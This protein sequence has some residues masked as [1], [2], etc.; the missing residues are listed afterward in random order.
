MPN[1]RETQ[2][3]TLHFLLAALMFGTLWGALEASVGGLLHAAL[4][5]TYPG[6]IL[7]VM[8]AALMAYAVRKTD[9]AWLPFGMAVVAAP[10]KLVSAPVFALPLTAPTVLNPAFAILA[11][12]L[13]FAA[14]AAATQ[15]WWRRDPR[16][17]A[18]SGAGAGL[19]QAVV[20]VAIVAGIG[21]RLYPS[22]ETIKALGTKYPSWAMSINTIASYL[23]G[24]VGWAVIGSALGALIVSLLP[25]GR[26]VVFRP[27]TLVLGS[28]ACLAIFAV[29]SGIY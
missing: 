27:A 14:A 25:L 19:T 7:I 11:Q 20:Y 23:T 13:A 17:M 21:L 18:I 8:A 26:P 29:V 10:L 2:S 28:A 15:T 5:P 16:V 1:G 22:A 24:V 6:R 4:P 3:T 9:H 12:G